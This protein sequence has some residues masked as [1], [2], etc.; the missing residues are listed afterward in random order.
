M[1]VWEL[2]GKELDLWVAKALGFGDK[3]RFTEYGEGDEECFFFYPVRDEQDEVIHDAGDRWYPSTEWAQ[4]GPIIERE[5]ISI[6][7]SG[8]AA[9]GDDRAYAYMIRAVLDGQHGET[10]LVAA[11]RVFIAS[12][13]GDEVS[14]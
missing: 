4:G 14:E 8:D 12:K 11:M 7:R 13:F 6:E 2:S 9:S 3:V 1:T 10:A 5:R